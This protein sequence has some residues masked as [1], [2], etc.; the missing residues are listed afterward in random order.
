MHSTLDVVRAQMQEAEPIL[1]RLDEELEAINFDPTVP[2]SVDA[3]TEKVTAIIDT[4]LASF[5]ANPILGPLAD[6]LKYQYLDSIQHQVAS[7]QEE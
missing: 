5:K 6:Q 1:K 7:A 3:A 4:L 2:S